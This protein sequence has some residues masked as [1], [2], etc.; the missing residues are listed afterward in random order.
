MP[1]FIFSHGVKTCLMLPPRR[2]IG[3]ALPHIGERGFVAVLHLFTL[4]GVTKDHKDGAFFDMTAKY[5][6]K[7]MQFPAGS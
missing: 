5:N 6:R 4:C 2:R 1:R 7:G 3:C